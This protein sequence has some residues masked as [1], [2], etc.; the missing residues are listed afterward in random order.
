M[1]LRLLERLNRATSRET[2]A[3]K[4][5]PVERG[6]NA[7]WKAK[8]TIDTVVRKA[9]GS[10]RQR[11]INPL[12]AKNTETDFL[13]MALVSY[14]AVKTTRSGEPKNGIVTFTADDT[15]LMS[16]AWVK[17]CQIAQKERSDKKEDVILDA[18]SARLLSCAT[19]TLERARQKP[20]ELRR[21]PWADGG[22][23]DEASVAG[24]SPGA[25]L[26]DATNDLIEWAKTTSD[27]AELKE[28]CSDRKGG[29][30]GKIILGHSPAA[31]NP[32]AALYLTRELRG[33]KQANILFSNP[34]LSEE[35][36]AEMAD[37]FVQAVERD[38][39][40]VTRRASSTLR[41]TLDTIMQNH[42]VP[43]ES[44]SQ[45]T[46][47]LAVDFFYHAHKRGWSVRADTIA[48]ITKLCEQ[49][50]NFLSATYIDTIC[51]IPDVV[52]N[53]DLRRVILE[54]ENASI[55]R[56]IYMLPV[57]RGE[58]WTE[59]W[60]EIPGYIHGRNAAEEFVLFGSLVAALKRT[61]ARNLAGVNR[62]IL[63]DLVGHE[64]AMVRREGNRLML[65][66]RTIPEEKP[67]TKTQPVPRK[68]F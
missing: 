62:Q 19:V 17:L 67:A 46:A 15:T 8:A 58:A 2:P 24:F 10:R 59:I 29:A 50:Q 1:S 68:Q 7:R 47:R 9:L 63:I 22:F 5:R 34:S 33:V 44:V 12:N 25:D 28:L 38:V 18:L 52:N 39:A 31:A 40:A 6:W 65:E 13:K 32:R 57:A 26:L 56:L 41:L 49:T 37:L 64:S 61:D 3:R 21:G 16:A 11:L 66:T 53:K 55:T 36:Y 30:F 51:G 60:T 42:S 23:A 48:R 20:E 14:I 45:T 54:C 35:T 43:E 27:T 4:R